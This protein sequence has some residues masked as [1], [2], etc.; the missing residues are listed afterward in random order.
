[1][2]LAPQTGSSPC[3]WHGRFREKGKY[4]NVQKRLGRKARHNPHVVASDDR[5]KRVVGLAELRVDQEIIHGRRHDQ[6][7]DHVKSRIKRRV[8]Y[9]RS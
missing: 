9:T 6:L 1:M 7:E 2:T 3:T 5:E 4:N 8:S